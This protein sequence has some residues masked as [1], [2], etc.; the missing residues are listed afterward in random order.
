[1]RP[2]RTGGGHDDRSRWLR[3]EGSE[4]VAGAQETKP[5]SAAESFRC[6]NL[7]CGSK[8]CHTPKALPFSTPVAVTDVKAELPLDTI[9]DI[10][11]ST[12]GQGCSTHRIEGK[13]LAVASRLVLNTPRPC[14]MILLVQTSCH[15]VPNTSRPF[16]L[17]KKQTS[18]FV[19]H[20]HTSSHRNSLSSCCAHIFLPFL[21]YGPELREFLPDITTNL[22]VTNG[23]PLS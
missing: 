22:N 17:G 18:L 11:D 3:E 13:S 14:L 15:V 10:E 20:Q 23:A 12:L 21:A 2:L 1:M 6:M 8:R 4:M 16:K 7:I 5:S 9:K 19:L